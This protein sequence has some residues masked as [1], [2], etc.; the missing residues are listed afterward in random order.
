MLANRRDIPLTTYRFWMVRCLCICFWLRSLSETMR[1]QIDMRM[2]LVTT[3]IGW[4]VQNQGAGPN[5]DDH[6]FWTSGDGANWKDIT[7]RDPSSRQ[8]AS[9][10]FLDASHGWVLLTVTGK[11]PVL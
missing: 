11:E 2:G 3:G 1:A 5:S 6:L 7:P 4:I 8:I 10:F 9:S